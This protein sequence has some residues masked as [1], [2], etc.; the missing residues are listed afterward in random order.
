MIFVL[1]VTAKGEV[2]L[3]AAVLVALGVGPGDRLELEE[4]AD[5]Y[6]LRPQRADS[7]RPAPLHDKIPRD[8]GAFDLEEFRSQPNDPKLRD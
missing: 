4:G 5:G 3:P 8:P 7:A 2:T 1:K 6:L